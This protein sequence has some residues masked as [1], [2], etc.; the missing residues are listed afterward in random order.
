MITNTGKDIIAKYLMGNAPAYASYMALGCGPKPR[1]AITSLSGASSATS[2]GVT[3]VTVS[4]TDGIWVGAK[5][6]KTSGTGTL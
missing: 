1:L 4:S 3:T 6:V 2:L 5:I